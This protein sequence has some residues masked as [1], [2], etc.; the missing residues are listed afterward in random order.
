MFTIIYILSFTPS[1]TSVLK[2]YTQMGQLPPK[3][4]IQCKQRWDKYPRSQFVK[5][6]HIQLHKNKRPNVF[7]SDVFHPLIVRVSFHTQMKIDFSLG[8]K[9][10]IYI[11]YRKQ[12]PMFSAPLPKIP[13][14]K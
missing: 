6:G 5:I 13:P 11:N 1:K 2:Q 7:L 3:Y 4:T 10:Y 12:Q 8:L 9:I 14:E